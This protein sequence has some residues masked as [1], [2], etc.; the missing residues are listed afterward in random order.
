MTEEKKIV[1]DKINELI[2][3]RR[4]ELLKELP[5]VHEVD[6]G[7]II[8][9]FTEWNAC[10]DNTGIKYKKIKNHDNPDESVVFFYIPQ[11]AFF[12]LKQRFYIGC[13]T[14]LNGKIDITSKNDKRLLESGYKICVDSDEVLGFALEN[15]YLVTTS[16]RKAWSK[17]TIKHVEESY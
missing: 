17:E 3:K 10:E 4:T 6:D 12:D 9:F 1:L 13:M 16:D 7:V 11:G 5:S 8:R 14:C 15:T 2:S